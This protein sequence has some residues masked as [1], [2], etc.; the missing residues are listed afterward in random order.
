M[1]EA[2]PAG[3]TPQAPTGSQEAAATPPGATAAPAAPA[4]PAAAAPAQGNATPAEPAA[5]A[6]PA[7]GASTEAQPAQPAG[8]P[9]KYE[10]QAPE[11][12]N[13]DPAVVDKFSAVAKELNLSQEAA[14]K[15]LSE[16]GPA[17]AAAQQKAQAEMVA[18]WETEAKADKEFGGENFERNLAI[19]KQ[20]QAFIG[21]PALAQ[22]LEQTKLGSHPE[23]IR[24]FFKVGQA[25]A[26][27]THVPG[28][29]RPAGGDKGGSPTERYATAL[30]G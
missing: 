6:K 18:S 3:G 5:A 2:L 4:A 22:F 17:M 24:L 13:F 1:S 16:V 27:D 29:A 21:T 10:F 7:E 26:E 8:A 30:Y 25:I 19:A 20:G 14:Q 15:V 23:V 12:V 9:E 28:G 11:G